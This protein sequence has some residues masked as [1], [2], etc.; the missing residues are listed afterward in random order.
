MA[1]EKWD[2]VF[3]KSNEIKAQ[4]VKFTNHYGITLVGDLYLPKN[5]GKTQKLPAIAISGPFGTVK[6]QVSGLC[7]NFSAKGIYHFSL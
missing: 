2:K 6:E 1:Q 3:A 7:A 5:L 4:K